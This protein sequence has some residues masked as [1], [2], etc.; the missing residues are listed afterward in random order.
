MRIIACTRS[1]ILS[2]ISLFT[3]NL[4]KHLR[5]TIN[6]NVKNTEDFISKLIDIKIDNDDRLAS[7]DVIDLFNNV[8]IS[9]PMGNVLS[10]LL[11]D[12]YMHEFI[13]N[14]LHKIKDKLFR[15]VDDL[16]IITKMC[17]TELESYVVSLNLN[18]TNIKFTCEYEENKQINFLD[19]TITRNLNEYKLDIK[20]F[21]KPA[22]SDRFLNFYSNYP[23]GLIEKTIQKCLQISINQQNLNE[24]NNNKPKPETK[25]TLSLPYVK[26]IEVLK[27]KLEQIGVKLYFSYPLKLKSLTT[28]NIKPQ[29]KS[30]IYQMNCK[31]GAI[32]NGETKVG[33]K[34]RMKQHK[35]KIKENDINSSSEIVKHHNIKNNGQCSF[36]PNKA[37]IIDNETNYWKRRKKETIYSIINESINK[38]DVIDNGWNNVIYKE[39]KKIKE[40]IKKRNTV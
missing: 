31:C 34:D 25:V 16:F 39:S 37:F 6:K 5:D 22:A 12:L 38:C 11:A 13:N 21:R 19:T 8:P 35:T 14:Q 23:K 2:S 3:F 4:I 7:L 40:I 29:S 28:L 10:P 32:Y 9:L 24:L 1:T 30:I 20:W 36:H 26:G 15:Y 17:K 27:R 33:L 18:R